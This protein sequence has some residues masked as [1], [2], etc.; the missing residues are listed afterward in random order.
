VLTHQGKQIIFCGDAAYANA[1]VWQPHHLE[2]DHWTGTGALAAWE[3]IQRIANLG[4][5]LLCPSHGPIIREKPQAMLRQLAAKLLKFYHAKGQICVGEPDDYWTPEITNNEA[6]GL[7][8][9]LYQFGKN[10][11]L[12]I[13]DTG[14]AMLIDP[15]SGD[16]AQ[17]LLKKL[18]NPKV[19]AATATRCKAFA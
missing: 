8:P 7:L 1:T 11:Y 6:K 14:K 3:G 15:W 18:G 16:L 12:L 9:H 4:M 10:S 2:W 13:S 5:Y 19:T 17:P